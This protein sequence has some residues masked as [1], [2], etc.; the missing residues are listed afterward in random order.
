MLSTVAG[1]MQWGAIEAYL[2]NVNNMVLT[3]IEI[4]KHMVHNLFI[5]IYI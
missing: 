5:I 4:L 3:L 2:A 1:C